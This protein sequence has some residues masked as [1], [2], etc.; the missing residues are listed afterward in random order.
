LPT[1]RK[2]K[3]VDEMREWMSKCTVAISADFSG[4][5]VTA[6]TDL[7]RALREAGVQ[8][9]VVKNNLA[10]LAADAAGRPELKDIVEGPTG[11]AFGYGDPAEPAKAL[12][13]YIRTNRSP[14]R[15]RCGVMG[16]RGLSAQEVDTLAT[17][18]SREELIARLL[19]QMQGPVAR[20]AIVLNSPISGLARVLQGRAESLTE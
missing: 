2:V 4:L 18:P 15:I 12:V 17:L 7:R 1:E 13:Q 10:Y 16:E 8:F 14:M 20:L 5:G 3:A 19:G 9:R 11:I 6:V